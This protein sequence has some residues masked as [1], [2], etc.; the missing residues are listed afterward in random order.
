MKRILII[1]VAVAA[2]TLGSQ[3]AHA[4]CSVEYKAKRDNPLELFY[5]VAQVGGD[6]NIAAVTRKLEKKLK[7]QGLT[8]LKVLSVKKQ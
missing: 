1:P 7:K 2:L 6:C 3:A 8:L 5:D 4:A